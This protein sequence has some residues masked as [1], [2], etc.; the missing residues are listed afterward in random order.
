[1]GALPVFPPMY[2][3]GAR[4]SSGNIGHPSHAADAYLSATIRFKGSGWSVSLRPITRFLFA[5]SLP[6]REGVEHGYIISK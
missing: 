1:V 4:R 3:P 2:T 5:A 6:K